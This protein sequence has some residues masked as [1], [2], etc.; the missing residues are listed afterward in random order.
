MQEVNEIRFVEGEEDLLNEIKTLWEKL[1]SYHK[2]KSIHF[3]NRFLNLYFEKRAIGLYERAKEGKLIVLLAYDN[4]KLIGYCISTID[5]SNIGEVDSL[6]VEAEYRGDNV[7]DY[8][9]K[10]SINWMDQ[11]EVKDKI[12]GVAAGNEMAFS[13]Y[14]RYG[15]YPKATILSQI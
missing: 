13:F 9:M 1:N 7:G 11:Y 2:S 10:K 15:F 4:Q 5:K 12:I 14:A 3:K 8:F 6:Y